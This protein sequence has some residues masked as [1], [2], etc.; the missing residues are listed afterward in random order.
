M[1]LFIA[2]LIS[3]MG[4][5]LTARDAIDQEVHEN[6]ARMAAMTA[7]SIDADLHAQLTDPGQ[8]E[9]GLYNM[10]NEPLSSAIRRTDGVRFVYTLRA[11][12]DELV[13]VLDGTPRGDADG[14][15]IEDHSFLMDLYEEPDPAAWDAIRNNRITTSASPY[16]D[17][18]GTFLSGYAPIRNQGGSVEGVVG[19][20][21]SVDQYAARL[22]R[23]DTAA[24]WALVPGLILSLF[25]G[26]GVWWVARRFLSH[27]N[28]IDQ[29]REEAVRANHAKS[30]LLANISHELRTPLNAIIGFSVIAGEEHCPGDEREEALSTVRSNADHLLTLINDLL[31]VSRA[32]AGAI[33][34][35][36]EE[37]DLPDLINRAVVPLRLRAMEKGILFEVEGIRSLPERVVMDRT[38]VRQVLLNLLSNAVKFTDSGRVRLSLDAS[39]DMLTLRVLDTG[40]GISDEEREQLFTPFT[41]LGVYEKRIQGTGL[42][43][44]IT[45]H[46]LGLMGGTIE[47]DSRLGEGSE[48][49]VTLPIEHVHVEEQTETNKPAGYESLP[50]LDGVRIAIA[51]DGEDNLRLFKTIL[52]RAGAICHEYPDGQAALEA[53]TYDPERFDLLITDW[54]MPVLDGD[55]LVRG[56]RVIGWERPIISLTAHLQPGQE[57]QC[58]DAGCN[59][60]LTKPIEAARL[61]RACVEMIEQDGTWR[62]AA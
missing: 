44:T 57:E 39:S 53:I 4:V 60:H 22:A 5:R 50:P 59:A 56:L 8:E 61:V 19:V 62:Q 32:E 46:L 28:Q 34:I 16:T 15:G 12:G 18:W 43:L 45:R 58:Y 17:L 52:Q 25:T 24:A 1:I 13:F 48:F 40:P 33:R 14:D 38:R 27:A 7:S 10:L 30:S 36:Y 41:Q 54:D 55:G 35:E 20:D 49:I 6:L 26:I 42:G 3:T 9:T 11:Q 47:I 31:D 2:A 21:V 23:V 37:V 51:D 29:H